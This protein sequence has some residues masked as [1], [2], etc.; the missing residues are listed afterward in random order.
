MTLDIIGVRITTFRGDD[1]TLAYQY[2]E[3]RDSFLT[4]EAQHNL[5]APLL[6]VAAKAPS[7]TNSLPEC[8]RDL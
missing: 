6:R 5:Q 7:R 8:R 3:I 4:A 2:Y 1:I